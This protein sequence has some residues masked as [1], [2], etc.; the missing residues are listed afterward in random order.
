MRGGGGGRAGG[1]SPQ[2]MRGA[3]G[4]RRRGRKRYGIF[5]QNIFIVWRPV[6]F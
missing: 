1:H 3:K 5:L 4:G 2:G 6:L